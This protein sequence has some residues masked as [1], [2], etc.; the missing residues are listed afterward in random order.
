MRALVTGCAGF[1]GSHLTETLLDAGHAVVGIDCFNDN[2]GRDQKLTNLRH[3]REWTDFEFVPIDLSH[4]DLLSFIQSTDVVF[5]LAAEPGVR[6]S[7]GGRY[8][9]YVRNNVL[10]TQ[11]LLEACRT[12][13]DTRMVFASSSSVYGDGDGISGGS[14]ETSP[15]RP[16]SPYGQTK[17]SAE[18]LCGLY[19]HELDLDVVC[20]RYF[21]V[22][23]PRQRPDMAFH[24]F[25]RAALTGAPI[26]VFG[27][28]RQTR[29]FT[30]VDDVVAATIAAGAAPDLSE[31]VLNIGGGSPTSL[32][33]VLELVRELVG[34]PID[35]EHVAREHGEVRDTC[36]QTGRARQ[37]LGFS[38]R[39]TLECGLR[40]EFEW[41]AD[42]L[43][44]S[45]QR[46]AA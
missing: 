20:L 33:R 34:R 4:G 14:S 7:W 9:R 12:A 41:L 19:R 28:G 46:L 42:L 5:H 43:E 8:E 1:I 17:L 21:T 32:L 44:G 24:K 38:P 6:M 11:H 2:Y 36:A 13:P 27:D 40:A 30:Y 37:A 39:T 26:K 25:L 22:F 29:D 16:R 31:R 23:G 15:T 35:V 10:A 3:V 18:Q 45:S